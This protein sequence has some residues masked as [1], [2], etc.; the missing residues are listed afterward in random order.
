MNETVGY[1]NRVAGEV[2]RCITTSAFSLVASIHVCAG[3][4][5]AVACTI[6]RKKNAIVIDIV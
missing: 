4:C 2:E 6:C 3:I 5:F 1:V